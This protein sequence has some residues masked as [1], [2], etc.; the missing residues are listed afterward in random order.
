MVGSIRCGMEE[1]GEKSATGEGF[2]FGC[3][4]AFQAWKAGATCLGRAM[5]AGW[6][7]PKVGTF[8]AGAA[9]AWLN[10]EKRA[11]PEEDSVRQAA[12]LWTLMTEINLL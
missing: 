8:R 10:L 11:R 12:I 3:R 7:T 9:P 1:E 6:V 4:W 2:V 5:M